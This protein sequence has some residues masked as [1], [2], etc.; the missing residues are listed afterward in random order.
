MAMSLRRLHLLAA[1]WLVVLS[2]AYAAMSP[3]SAAITPLVESNEVREGQS[4]VLTFQTDTADGKPD[5]SPLLQDFEVLGT[6]RRTNISIENGRAARM[7]VWQVNLIPKRSG[8]V[9]V[10]AIDFGNDRSEALSI[11]VT[12]A[13]SASGDVAADA[14]RLEV[15]ATPENPYVQ[16]QV[17][18]TVRLF[19]PQAV[20]LVDSAFG[21]PQVRGG[22]ALVTAVGKT[23]DRLR[24][25][26][27]TRE[28]VIE[29]TYAI[30]PQHHGELVIEPITFEGQIFVS[31]ATLDNPFGQSIRAQ[32]LQSTPIRLQVKPIPEAFKGK[33][34]LPATSLTLVENWSEENTTLQ[35]GEPLTRSL[36]LL[37]KGLTAGQLP[38][39]AVPMPK[40]VKSYP[41]TPVL[42]DHGR[43]D[44]VSGL[45]MEKQTLII[46]TNGAVTLPE[47]RIPW[48]N[49]RSD[50]LEEAVIAAHTLQVEG[51]IAAAPGP[52]TAPAASGEAVQPPPPA[53]QT[54]SPPIS[55]SWRNLAVVLALGWATT[56]LLWWRTHHRARN[57]GRADAGGNAAASDAALFVDQVI[58]GAR[59]NDAAA[60]RKA[61]LRW[62]MTQQIA[63]PTL[64]AIARRHPVLAPWLDELDRCLYAGTA[65]AWTGGQFAESF[66]E[67]CRSSGVVRGSA[68]RH[69]A[70]LAPLYLTT[71]MNRP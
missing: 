37:A 26:R 58:A 53:A 42:D 23:R 28:R 33:H 9:T 4:F 10:P 66:A 49:T 48:W 11:T 70:V 41:E 61:L 44:G 32:R 22:D 36:T 8:T 50:R 51:G 31:S 65:T 13:A 20:D 68:S 29:R 39:I 24:A 34:W 7:T 15:T 5:F 71:G 38:E 47:I 52:Q 27:G 64:D 25:D 35:A 59:R 67:L 62:A 43:S 18:L 56:A 45:R 69:T 6:A 19:V 63:P 14:L 30:F 55:R 46:N 21:E 17:L 60:T 57:A 40:A 16:A 3:A 54:P 12:P 2:L 1:R